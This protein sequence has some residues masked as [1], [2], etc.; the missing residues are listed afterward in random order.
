M[1]SNDDEG[2]KGCGSSCAKKAAAIPRKE[3]IKHIYDN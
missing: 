1:V 2:K 3:M